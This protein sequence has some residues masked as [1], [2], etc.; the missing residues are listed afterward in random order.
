MN[1]QNPRLLIVLAVCLLAQNMLA[2]DMHLFTEYKPDSTLIK[3]NGIKSLVIYSDYAE[4][5][6]AESNYS[7]TSKWMELSFNEEGQRTY[8]RTIPLFRELGYL[9]LSN[10]TWQFFEYDSLHRVRYYR[11]K[12]EHSDREEFYTFNKD[13]RK[14][15]V[16]ALS[17]GEPYN[18]T[19]FKWK[20]DKL[21]DYTSTMADTALSVFK[22]TYGV[23]GKLKRVEYSTV[24]IE[25]EY[26][27][28]ADANEESMKIFHDD[29]VTSE[30][31][32]R[33]NSNG[34]RL[35]YFVSFNEKKDTLKEIVAKF[36]EQ[37][38][39]SFYHSK[40]F[41]SRSDFMEYSPAPI[42]P[43]GKESP[44]TKN[45]LP[46]P[47]ESI[48]EIENIYDN[49]GLLIKQKYVEIDAHDPTKKKLV[50][51]Q[52]FIYETSELL[53]QPLPVEEVEE[54]YYPEGDY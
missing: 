46:P 32:M 38:N 13:N 8:S 50:S 54:L 4:E 5:G 28:V 19:T 39:I 40:D 21:V 41:S 6:M 37:K 47:F 18:T 33:M 12:T 45:Q 48:Y 31:T 35:E 11:I 16:V 15:H 24:R 17:N 25:F 27:K 49:R 20:G 9:G 53:I 22:Y 44:S 1:C 14:T 52:R 2:Q 43:K 29:K 10:T 51:I 34:N 23:D 30:Q 36:D 3:K 26:T 42:G 7:V